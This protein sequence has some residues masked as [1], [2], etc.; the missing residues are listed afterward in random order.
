MTRRFWLVA[1]LGLL[2]L[3]V[4]VLYD[5]ESGSD[6]TPAGRPPGPLRTVFVGDSITRGVSSETFEPDPRF[7]WVGYAVTTTGTPWLLEANVGEPGRTLTEMEQSF[8]DEVVLADPEAVVIMGGTNDTLRQAPVEQS[9]A[10]LRAMITAAQEVGIWVWVVAP[11]PLDPSYA[12]DLGPLLDAEAALATEL[13][14]P[15]IDVR[16]QLSLPTGAWDT[17]LSFDGVHPSKEGARRIAALVLDE[18]EE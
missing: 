14:V 11:P 8:H 7:S 16:D 9:V 10:S 17:N 12:R 1:A 6:D 3:G 15:Y 18:V 4:L 13:G 5:A 2:V